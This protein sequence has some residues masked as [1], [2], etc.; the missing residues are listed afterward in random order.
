MTK[1]LTLSLRIN[2]SPASIAAESVLYVH[3]RGTPVGIQI[4]FMCSTISHAAF[5]VERPRGDYATHGGNYMT[6]IERVKAERELLANKMSD[7]CK[8]MSGF[9]PYPSF[10]HACNICPIDG[11]DEMEG[12]TCEVRILEW[13]Q[14]E[15]ARRNDGK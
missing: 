9:L 15:I 13:A 6:E 2:A 11:D 3:L 4:A 1:G 8:K 14:C 7:I 12:V 10:C 5:G